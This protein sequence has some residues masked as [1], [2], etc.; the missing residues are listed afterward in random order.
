[1]KI[2]WILLGVCL[3][4]SAVAMADVPRRHWW[5]GSRARVDT[6][7]EAKADANRD[8]FVQPTEARRAAYLRNRSDVDRPWEKAADANTDGK[9]D[10][11]ELRV[12][13]RAQ[14]DANHDGIITVA[15]RKG[16]WRQKRACVDTPAERR[17]DLDHDGYLSWE[18]GREYLKDRLILI[19]TH[20]RA[21]VDT[22]LELEFDT[23]GD[24]FIDRNEAVALKAAL[25]AG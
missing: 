5:R 18:E 19:Q 13:H 15:E 8:G 16:Y 10:G 23:D 7:R 14:L 1:M 2:R 4:T 25:D 11:T 21:V 12:F 20:G 24:G 22:D 6:P 3:L 9:V 17:Y